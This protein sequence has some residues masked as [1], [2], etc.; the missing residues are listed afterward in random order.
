MFTENDLLNSE[1]LTQEKIS[2]IMLNEKL[3]EACSLQED[4]VV[5]FWQ[6]Q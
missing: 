6:P 5:P 4:A 2:E 1:V 3:Q